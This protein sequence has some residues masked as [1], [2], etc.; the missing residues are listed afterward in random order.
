MQ[1]TL[2]NIKD[3]ITMTDNASI[4]GKVSLLSPKFIEKSEVGKQ[5]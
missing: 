1:R 5:K 3:T 4:A 2:Y